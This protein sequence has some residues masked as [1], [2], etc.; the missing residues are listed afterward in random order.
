[1]EE[2]GGAGEGQTS[3]FFSQLSKAKLPETALSSTILFIRVCS[4]QTLDQPGVIQVFRFLNS[5][6]T[7]SLTVSGFVFW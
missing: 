3:I 1:M 6:L 4:R 5:V 2:W 7:L